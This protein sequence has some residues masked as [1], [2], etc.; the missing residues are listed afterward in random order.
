MTVKFWSTRGEFGPFSNFSRH[1]VTIGKK[2]YKTTEHYYQAQKFIKT[3]TLWCLK[4]TKATLPK[5]AARMGRNRSKKMRRDWESVKVDI[6]RKA[7]RVKAEQHPVIKELLLG[8]GDRKIIE[9]S[10][11][12]WY[13]GCGSDGKG[14]NMLGRLWMEL[15]RELRGECGDMACGVCEACQVGE[16]RCCTNPQP[17]EGP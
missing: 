16:E 14:K 13:W 1:G 9:D 3:D 15:R 8:T 6:M 5:E 4:I 11:N 17:L 12:D 7:L 10:P 2:K